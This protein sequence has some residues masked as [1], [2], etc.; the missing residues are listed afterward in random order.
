LFAKQEMYIK[1]TVSQGETITQIAQKYK[2]T[3]FDI[4]KLNPDAQNGIQL[5]SILL[6]PKYSSK[7]QENQENNAPKNTL[8]LNT[9]TTLHL[10]KQKESLF[11]ISKLYQ[12]PVEEIR[13]ANKEVL[14]NGLQV[15]QNIIIPVKGASKTDSSKTTTQPS[16]P[17]KEVVQSTKKEE[18]YQSELDSYR[19]HHIIAPQE[20]KFGVAKRYGLTIEELERLNPEIA[21]GFPVGALIVIAKNKNPNDA[22][23]TPKFSSTTNES[24]VPV[25]LVYDEHVVQPK[26][27]LYSLTR[28][29]GITEQQLIFLNPEVKNGLKVGMI[30]RIPKAQKKDI[31]FKEKV[32]LTKTLLVDKKKSVILL[33]PFNVSKIESDTVNSTEARLKKDKFLNL[34]LDFYSGA[35]MAIDSAK[36]LGLN[37]DVKIF[38]SQETKN[39]SSLLALYTNHSFDSASAIIGPFYQSN[40]EKLAEW[41]ENSQTPIISPLSKDYAKSYPNLYQ[42]LPSEDQIRNAMFGFMKSKQGNVVAVI[43][44]KKQSIYDYFIK[45]QP[46]VKIVGLSDKGTLVSDSLTTKLSKTKLNYV[47]L[48]TEKTSMIMNA[49]AMLQKLKA[50]YQLQLAILEYNETLDFEEVKLSSLT[51]LNMMFPSITK[52]NDSGTNVGFEES[53]K[54]QN[55]IFPNQYAVRGF[56]VTLDTLLRLSQAKTYEESIRSTATEYVESKFDYEQGEKGYKNNGVFILYYD[57]DLTIKEAK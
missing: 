33:L 3:P 15:G 52:P 24:V 51:N 1:H 49:T 29:Y 32:D 39:N 56:D 6:I 35:L 4:Y 2:V 44:S 18:E 13:M 46:D 50:D 25:K 28:D 45:S 23:K 43:D 31:L 12:I 8:A 17:K 42:S 7:V 30:I 26:E 14:K 19:T 9:S 36:T 34:T 57:T 27:T 40:V 53:Y 41:L 54:K 16:T 47:V 48:V 10:V 38:D 22:A 37:I 20:T 11:S 5:N 55:N 21:D